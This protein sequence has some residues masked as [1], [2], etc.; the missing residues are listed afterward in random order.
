MHILWG[1]QHSPTFQTHYTNPISIH[2]LEA[3]KEDQD[4]L[5]LLLGTKNRS[6]ALI[7]VDQLSINVSGLTT[8]MDI[9][10]YLPAE[11]SIRTRV[12]VPVDPDLDQLRVIGKVSTSGEQYL[13]IFD[14]TIDLASGDHR[15]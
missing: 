12:V 6:S 8:V 15:H 3:T 1:C 10:I 2:V 14:R 5:Q 7:I 11:S 4:T 9:Q 13:A